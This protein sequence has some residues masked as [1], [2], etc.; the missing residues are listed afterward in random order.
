MPCDVIS[1]QAL[2]CVQRKLD[3]ARNWIITWVSSLYRICT[4]NSVNLSYSAKEKLSHVAIRQ[5]STETHSGQSSYL[6]VGIVSKALIR[7]KE[8]FIK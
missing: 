3:I 1:L 5:K 6:L 4:E 8:L 7:V 2:K